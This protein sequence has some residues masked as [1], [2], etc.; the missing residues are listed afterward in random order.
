MGETYV[1]AFARYALVS[2]AFSLIHS[3]V[4]KNLFKPVVPFVMADLVKGSPYT[5]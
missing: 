2:L 1:L 5:L 3:F 4:E